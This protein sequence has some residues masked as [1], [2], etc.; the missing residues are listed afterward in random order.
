MWA[1][2]VVVDHPPV[3]CFA[4]VFE[5]SE[6]VLV[7]DPLAEGAIESL[8]VR[9]LVGLAWLDVSQGHAVR[10]EPL[11]EALTQGLRAVV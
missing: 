10:L 2:L 3:R 9:V 4:H 8:D 5:T 1:L 7:E 6:K 11:N